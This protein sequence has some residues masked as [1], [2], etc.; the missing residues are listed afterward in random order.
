MAFSSCGRQG[1]TLQWRC[2]GFSLR[3]LLLSKSMGSGA[4]AQQLCCM[5]LVAQWHLCIGRWILNHWTTRESLICLFKWK[6]M[7]YSH[8]HKNQCVQRGADIGRNSSSP[9][10]LCIST[11][12]PPA[13]P[14]PC[15][16][17]TLFTYASYMLASAPT[18]NHTHGD[19]LFALYFFF[20]LNN[21]TTSSEVVFFL[22]G[23]C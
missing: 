18:P 10:R 5:G 17:A 12:S 7:I 16:T 23:L 1:A 14:A 11:W 15:M 9:F 13:L 4:Q 8:S 2:A 20:H 6:E 19:R 22:L 21:A 3:W